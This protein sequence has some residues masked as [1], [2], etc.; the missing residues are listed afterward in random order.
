MYIHDSSACSEYIFL[1][2]EIEKLNDK[3][4]PLAI[5]NVE[6]KTHASQVLEENQ[7][8]KLDMSAHVEENLQLKETISKLIKGK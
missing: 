1:E 2:E 3:Y 4:A 7:K 6:L 8:L 5:E